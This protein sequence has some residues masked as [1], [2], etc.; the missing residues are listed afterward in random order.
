[1]TTILGLH[2]VS[3]VTAHIQRTHA[4]HTR[5]L[6]MR[7]VAK[8]VNQ[9]DPSMY[10]LFYGDGEGSPGSDITMFDIPGAVRERRGNNS[11]TLTTFRVAGRGT[12]EYWADRL[13]AH[14]VAHEGIGAR[15]GR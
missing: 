15:D 2:H 6:G 12:L 14:D 1:M 13:R 3:A 11:I 7:T 8:S 9:D 4:F 10:H 5:V